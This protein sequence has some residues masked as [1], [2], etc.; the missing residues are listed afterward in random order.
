MGLQIG[1]NPA[2]VAGGDA[3]ASARARRARQEAARRE[4]IA[5]SLQR[6]KPEPVRAGF[7]RNTLSPPAAALMT[8]GANLE[9]A[10]EV[11]PTFEELRA[12]LRASREEAARKEAQR[13]SRATFDDAAGSNRAAEAG[14]STRS[15]ATSSPGLSRAARAAYAPE[16][17]L[18]RQSADIPA[19]I[20]REEAASDNRPTPGS[21]AGL[22][23]LG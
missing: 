11:V 19:A 5:P 17:A 23:L 8:L 10:R 3:F 7:G 1:Q 21:T 9:R 12:E 14:P 18:P 6:E 13:Q 20:P 2:I 4:E 16:T 22:N 15:A